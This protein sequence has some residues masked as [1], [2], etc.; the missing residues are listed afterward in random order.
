[1]RGAVRRADPRGDL[2]DQLRDPLAH[3]RVE[4][5]RRAP[6]HGLAGDHVRRITGVDAADRHHRGLQRIDP[7]RDD[8][9][10]AADQLRRRRDGVDGGVGEAGVPAATRDRER[11]EVRGGHERPRHR[12]DLAVLQRRPQ[13]AAVDEVHALHHARRDHVARA[14]GSELLGVLEDEPQ[15]AAG[16]VPRASA[17]APRRA[18]SRCARRARTRASRPAA[19]RRTRRRS[20][21]GSAARRCPRAAR[22]SARACP[23]RSRARTLVSVGRSTSSPPNSLSRSA[24]H[25][26][27][28]C[29]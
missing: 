8:V 7:A 14:A 24:I 3:V 17:R 20:P 29:S 2:L 15:L 4:R 27:V 6:Q 18:A 19:R 23:C 1:M 12:G 10:Q 22:P 28:S 13:M 9:L 11:E 26:E 25:A 16:A 5:A 21:H